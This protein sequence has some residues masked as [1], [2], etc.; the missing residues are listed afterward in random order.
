MMAY[1]NVKVSADGSTGNV[2][3]AAPP[4]GVNGY[5]CRML[6]RLLV[7]LL[8]AL[9]VS[10]CGERRTA[11]GLAPLLPCEPSR[12]ARE[13]AAPTAS[14]RTSLVLLAVQ[15][16]ARFG[17]QE[18]DFMGERPRLVFRGVRED[19]KADLVSYQDAPRRVAAYWRA[20]GYP[21]RE[22]TDGIPWSAAFISWLFVNAGVDFGDFCPD[23]THAVYVE[24]IV[25]RARKP[26]PVL[27]P[28][29]PD[30]YSPRPGD[31]V[32]AARDRSGLALDN[33]NRGAGHC[34]IVVELRP[35]A[36]V[37]VGGNVTDSVSR[38]IF[39]IDSSGRLV[40]PAAR[41]FFVVIEN[42]LP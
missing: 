21:A 32:C 24:R 38:S 4:V 17:G 15:E 14:L 28:H 40:A 7:P 6:S 35:G 29:R 18:I 1:V 13:G 25:E 31:L 34:D 41:P 37:T 26:S 27:V 11:A 5:G 36:L 2:S 10:A 33:L 19:G 23:Q 30:A 12:F 22:G 16:W 42:R 20:T 9:V 8:L 3:R 39:A